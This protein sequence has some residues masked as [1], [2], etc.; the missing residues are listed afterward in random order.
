M[1]SA[2]QWRRC[3]LLVVHALT[4][5]LGS[6]SW[7]LVMRGISQSQE[8][9]LKKLPPFLPS[10][11]RLASVGDKVRVRSIKSQSGEMTGS[12]MI[13]HRALGRSTRNAVVNEQG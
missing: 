10:G 1:P 12:Y 8:Y 7:T 3:R 4:V 5:C 2:G 6:V 11:F 9:H 13:V